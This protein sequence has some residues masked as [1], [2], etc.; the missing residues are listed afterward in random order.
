MPPERHHPR[1][2]FPDEFGGFSPERMCRSN[3][4]GAALA[5]VD[6]DV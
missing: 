4:N 2:R 6:K 3:R 1:Q 5:R